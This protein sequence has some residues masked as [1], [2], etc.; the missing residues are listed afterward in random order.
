MRP[1]SLLDAPSVPGLSNVLGIGD[2]EKPVHNPPQQR[3]AVTLAL[4]LVV[5]EMTHSTFV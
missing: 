3:V 1:K 4:G 2:I 5:L